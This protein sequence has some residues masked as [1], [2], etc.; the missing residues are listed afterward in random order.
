MGKF[1][2][3][4]QKE[5][6]TKEQEQKY[7]AALQKASEKIKMLLEEVSSLK[8]QDPV[9][10]IGMSC[11][12]PGGA[13]TP[14]KFWN[15]LAN[16]VDT[17]TDIPQQRWN[18]EQYYDPNPG[19]PGKMY[20]K[21][22][23]FL[24][25]VETFDA[26]FFGIAPKEADALD[27]QQRLL[28]EV[29]WEALEN[30]GLDPKR[31]R[32]SRT[33]VF[34][35]FSSHDYAAA[36]LLSGIPEK[37]DP[38]AMTGIAFSTGCGRLS[39]FYDFQGPSLSTDTACSS[40]LVALHVAV[41]SLN[42]QESDLA[43]VGG[44]NVFLLPETFVSFCQLRALAPD[45]RCKTF[46]AA[47]DGYGRGEGCG[48][49]VL[50]RL[51]EA[52]RDGDRIL[53]VIRGTA[54]NQ[55]GKSS[56]LTAPNGL[57]QKQ[58]IQT[59]LS[60]AQLSPADVDYIE[61]HGT[62][63][64]LG[65]PIEV[66]ALGEVFRNRQE[67]LLLGSVKTN[68]GH[69][70]A[71]AGIAGVI[72]VILAMQHDAI[73][74][75][76][77]FNAPNPHIP[78]NEL[79][80]EV[81]T[82]LFP[83]RLNDKPR[84]AGIS[85]FGFSGTNAHVILS[86]F[87]LK[88]PP[89]INHQS[90]I[91]NRKSSIVNLLTLSAKSEKALRELAE[92]YQ[93]YLE[94]YPDTN[95]GNLCFT[96]NIGRMD[97]HHRLSV[98][99]ASIEQLRE[100]LAA[101]HAGK[102]I[103]NLFYAEVE[104]ISTPEISFQET[105]QQITDWQPLLSHLAQQYIQGATIDWNG[106]GEYQRIALPTY[107]FQRERYWIDLPQQKRALAPR[108]NPEWFYH[109]HWQPT[110]VASASLGVEPG[111][112]NPRAGE[113]LIFAD[114]QGLGN[115]LAEQLSKQ[116]FHC[117]LVYAG[118]IF[119]KHDDCWDINPAEPSD[120]ARFFEEHAHGSFQKIVH[121]WSLDAETSAD[122][123]L[124]ALQKAIDLGCTSVLYLTQSLVKHHQLPH[125]WIV[126][127]GA[128]PVQGP[129]VSPWQSPLWGMS[130]VLFQEHPEMRGGIIDLAPQVWEDEL[131]FLIHSIFNAG[132]EDQIA[133]RNKQQYVARLVQGEL[134]QHHD[135]AFS[136]AATYLLTG[137]LGTLGLKVAQWMVKQGAKH[138]VLTGR[139]KPSE[140]T[141]Q[142]VTQLSI[143]EA[144]I[145]YFQA[146]VT[147]EV[148]VTGVLQEI[149]D[150]LPP[151]RGIV[152]AAGMLGFQA[153]AD[154]TSEEFHAVLKPKVQ[155][156]WILHCL[157]RDLPLD[158][159]V[160]F[161]SIA[162]VWGSIKQSHYAAANHFLDIFAHYRQGLGLPALSVNWGPWF[163]GNMTSQEKMNL[164]ARIGVNGI[165]SEQMITVLE[166]LLGTE[167]I[168]TVV[169]DI[170][171]SIFKRQY[172]VRGKRPLLEEM[173]GKQTVPQPDKESEI[174]KQFEEAPQER[175]QEMLVSYLQQ[176]VGQILGFKKGQLPELKKGFFSMGMESLMAIDLQNKVSED[177]GRTFPATLAFEYPTITEL[178][179]YLSGEV[180][181]W[182]DES[183]VK[184]APIVTRPRMRDNPEPIAIIGMECRFPG[185]ENIEDFWQLLRN[186]E[187][188]ISEVP[189]DRWD[190]EAFYD[191]DSNVLGKMH[192]RYGGFVSNVDLFDAGFFGLSPKEARTMD[193]QQRLLLEVSWEAL[194]Y[195]G[196]AP[197]SLEGSRTGVFVG[198]SAN[199]YSQMLIK[200]GELNT[201]WV[202]GNS[203]NAAAGRISYTLGL[204]G[205]SLVIDTAC[206]SALVST[207]TACQSLLHQECDLA[208]A[209]G[210]NLILSPE[211]TLALC[212]AG[213]MSPDGCC[214][215]FDAAANGYVRGEGCGV[216]VLKRLSD[217]LN[218]GNR[219]LAVIQGSAVNQDG[220]SGGFT[221]PNGS[222]Q[223]S[224]IRQALADANLSPAE[225]DYVEA[226]G[227]GTPLGDPI[228]I[229]ALGR[230]LSEGRSPERPLWVGA[231]KTNIGHL[232]SAAGMAS[233]IKLVLSLQ[234][235]EIPPHLHLTDPNP[236]IPWDEFQLKVPT[237]LIPWNSNHKKRIAGASGFG[238]SGTNAHIIL[239]EAPVTKPVLQGINHGIHLLTLSAQSEET[240]QQLAARY[241]QYITAHPDIL[242]EDIC[243][244]A[245][246]GRAAF[247]H[248]LSIFASTTAE[249]YEKLIAFRA[250]KQI[251]GLFTGQVNGA[252]QGEISL[253]DVETVQPV[254][255]Q[256]VVEN[257]ARSYIQGERI[258]WREFYREYP[259]QWVD[260]PTYP[261]QRKRHWI[262]I[263]AEDGKQ[264]AEGKKKE[265]GK[266]G[267]WEVEKEK[268]GEN[269]ESR[270]AE[271]SG[272][273]IPILGGVRGGSESPIP[274]TS[275][276]T[277]FNQQSSNG[278]LERIFSQQLET[279]SGTL[280]QVV[281]QQLQFIR[282]R[283][284]ALDCRLLIDDCRLKEDVQTEDQQSPIRQGQDT[285]INNQQFK[286]NRQSPIA[287]RQST[288]DNGLPVVFM[289]PGLGDHYI[290]MGKGLYQTEPSFREG[291]DQCCDLLKFECHLDVKELLYPPDSEKK[292][293][294]QSGKPKIDLKKLLG[295]SEEPIDKNTEKLNQTEFAH[296]TVFLIEYALAK[297]WMERGLQPYAM[298]GQSLGEYAAACISGVMS[299][300]DALRIVVTRAQLIQQLP[301]GGMLAVP[302]PEEKLLPL[303]VGTELSVAVISTPSICAVA[304][305]QN[306]LQ[307]LEKT[308]Q[309]EN[310]VYRRLQ[311]SHAFHS[312]MLEPIEAEYISFLKTI[313]LKP[314][315]IPYISNVTGTWITAAQTTDPYYWVQ[316]TCATVRFAEGMSTLLQGENKLFLEVG[317]GQSLSSFVLQHP[318]SRGKLTDK[319]VLQSLRNLNDHQTD[320]TFLLNTTGKLRLAGMHFT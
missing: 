68:I 269:K 236:D 59:A 30:A 206:S 246:T 259:H 103:E 250:G 272:Q 307:E 91:E 117:V 277:G 36:H 157:T 186:G 172:E 188:A 240:L 43:L 228:E 64:I 315:E 98:L 180:L 132:D 151:L 215:T 216:L 139:R 219:V 261:F 318:D 45:G 112:L 19:T 209:G 160:C 105:H 217:A 95:L 38:Y 107:P 14:E 4:G 33:G 167:Q 8:R 17:V 234:H 50:K 202:T 69:L 262:E 320:E 244:A 200:A 156:T 159:F 149:T 31:L 235:Q 198:I 21:Q 251:K 258:N 302:L 182:P 7:K 71:G 316:H 310:V 205:P 58:V 47:A 92:R 93:Q 248:R 34:M 263:Q 86:D 3:L 78:W 148:D 279:M 201:F 195:A 293:P 184:A 154:M 171:W 312:K 108:I 203:L 125:L 257:L 150:S 305:H 111:V 238:A 161:S 109:I 301:Q 191:P 303:L 164:L 118:K 18:V 110:Q 152:H 243:F 214:K 155:G 66:Q 104:E 133:F 123:N 74:P 138:L 163:G 170:D 61:A 124:P 130:R 76:L 60:R 144:N 83:W 297:F 97:F 116:G 222:A 319:T 53:T 134:P 242:I 52:Q 26:T 176:Q 300:E 280:S 120:F 314:P 122:S 226:H 221:V 90:P 308:L 204:Q 179:D 281:A 44:V 266:L 241:E 39:Y 82:R 141:R 286:A 304:G 2:H 65:D 291:V 227:T 296:P 106:Y 299:F 194:E 24:D 40:S 268:K 9:A 289:F 271:G 192:T 270:R 25:N 127:R 178:A 199:D 55:D 114:R 56:G 285:T 298:I 102:Q 265:A 28:L 37:I 295:R 273:D 287:N 20:T 231:V 62:G 32:G 185:A 119:H 48:V 135:I 317:P 247:N 16:G 267:S 162:S 131:S 15:L 63:T 260:L 229:R 22:A 284:G 193:P 169:A 174:L 70:E 89:D 87:R 142:L 239:A 294:P 10:V 29:S 166:F 77:H 197:D 313:A 79:P 233:L 67:K 211:I 225:V 223:Q 181:Q 175:R 126:T 254:E 145:L 146:D 168:Q 51:S 137:G 115:I 187:C 80:M 237:T 177:F 207:H 101:F 275:L 249:L 94:V 23:A 282:N 292:P 57:A 274:S 129:P 121:L 158:F 99:V 288:I 153:I 49:V 143:A 245:N 311:V 290:N 73:P 75:S 88:E 84:V 189:P 213:I 183:R 113:I 147:S 96:A 230:V 72:K 1:F 13:D 140:A 208:L 11:R 136:S 165:E 46:S 41:R 12:F 100:T 54:I 253:P 224:L 252:E 256:Q 283:G 306:A 27:P 42:Q 5:A 128:M 309:K 6:M 196:I 85:S 218:D 173:K 81:T 264:E 278:R 212:K 232:E 276:R 210:V 255:W 35:G 190:I 220:L